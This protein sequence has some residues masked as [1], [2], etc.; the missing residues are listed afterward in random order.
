MR[1]IYHHRTQGRGVEAVHIHGVCGGLKRLGYEVEIIGPPGVDTDPDIVVAAE[2]GKTGTVWG[3][4]AKSAPQW[5]FEL[6]EVGYNLVA[7]PRVLRRCRETEASLL[8]ERY[9][10]Y[11]ATAAF[12]SMVTGVPLILEVNDT[13]G[14]DR[15]RQGKS[16]QMKPL[17]RAFEKWI[18]KRTAGITVVSGY[19]REQ[20]I[21]A[22]VPVEII[23]VTPNAVDFDRFNRGL[24]DGEA[25]RERRGL[26]SKTVVGF[27]G[28]FT[29]WHGLDL[30][31]QAFANVSKDFKDARLL[32]VGDGAKMADTQE[33]VA[34]LK[35][36][37]RVVFTGKVGHADV[38]E[39][40]AAMDIGVMPESNVFGS[41]MKVYEYMAMGRPA[42]GPRYG[43]LEEAILDGEDGLIFEPGDLDG[44]TRCLR[45]LLADPERRKA[46]GEAAHRKVMSKHQWVHNAE[47]AIRLIEPAKKGTAVRQSL[48]GTSDQSA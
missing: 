37:D 3:V 15:T 27:A 48:L 7:I 19:L 30:L 45:T 26:K 31:V 36:S 42:V 43:P 20:V 16:T 38:P 22:G 44:L 32:L 21:A 2:A 34:S 11:N 9:S 13:V 12:V 47:A 25:L 35:I 17:A 41:P 39:H 40:M 14:T 24:V 6:M 18:F 23:A 1:A 29:K 8:Y 4:I 46:M 28:S 10:L 33:Q 5:L